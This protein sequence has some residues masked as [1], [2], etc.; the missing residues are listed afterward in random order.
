MVRKNDASAIQTQTSLAL[1][2]LD[3]PTTPDLSQPLDPTNVNKALD[4]VC[5]LT[6]IGPAT[7]TLILSVFAPDCIPFFQDEMFAWFFPDAGKLKYNLKEYQL[8]FEAVTPVLTRLSCKAVELEKVAYV[9]GHMD[10][11]DDGERVML[12]KS[13]EAKAEPGSTADD[14]PKKAS[15][16]TVPKGEEDVEMDTSHTPQEQIAAK[17]G[18]KRTV[19]IEDRQN[20]AKSAA[21]PAPRGKKRSSTNEDNTNTE[22][23]TAKRRSQRNR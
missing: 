6:G 20:P 16:R 4:N 17:E 23:H 18:R 12:E 8:L 1:K 15:S 22:T 13:F 10:L 9:L 14:E 7:G 5:K 19:K 2:E 11:L 21:A 3:L